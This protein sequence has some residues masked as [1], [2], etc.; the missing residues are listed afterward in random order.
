VRYSRMTGVLASLA[1]LASCGGDA[2]PTAVT[3]TSAIAIGGPYSFSLYQGAGSGYGLPLKR[4]GD[5]DGPVTMSVEGVPN[6][7]FVTEW[8]PAVV[9]PAG[10]SNWGFTI[11]ADDTMPPGV[12]QM[13]LRA[14]G[15]GVA[16]ATTVVTINI[17]EA[18]FLLHPP[19]GPFNVTKG[20][21]IV[22]DIPITRAPGLAEA[23]T[24]APRTIIPGV[25]FTPASITTTGTVATFTIHASLAAS[26]FGNVVFDAS[27]PSH[28]L[29]YIDWEFL[30]YVV[31]VPAAVGDIVHQ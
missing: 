11:F 3:P 19:K 22:I 24:I 6:G 25:S 13:L 28:G 26:S 12:Y 15:D 23:V 7:L 17:L 2:L 16:D 5:F 14:R 4:S 27:T 8:F 1:V 18:P 10:Q 30:V 21:D 9:V 29:M 20:S 31:D